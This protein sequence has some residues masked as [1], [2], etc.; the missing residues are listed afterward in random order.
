MTRTGFTMIPNA[1]I[2]TGGLTAQ[3]LAV[4][5][6]LARHVDQTRKCYPGF[7]RIGA[8]ANVSRETV[9]R[10]VR[11]LEARGLVCVER[12]KVG[13]KNLSNVYT[14]PLEVGSVSAHVGAER[15][16]GWAQTEPR[17]RP[18][19][20]THELD[21]V[22]RFAQH[23][24]ANEDDTSTA[25]ESRYSHSSKA[26]LSYL[27]DLHIFSEHSPPNAALI[28]SWRE[29]SN[30]EAH[31]R[32]VELRHNVGHGDSYYGPELGEPAYELLSVS[33]QQWADAR[34]IPQDVT[35]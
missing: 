7:G 30:A 8:V 13:G 27:R 4:Y 26:Q 10:A 3:E 21:N 34:M 25:V 23:E 28:D 2:D 1:V 18:S 17:T 20:N 11:T 15:A 24:S 22:Q 31:Q 29:L 6:A 33:G 9:K 12:R 5:A 35:L 32:I 16:H 14:L 19:N